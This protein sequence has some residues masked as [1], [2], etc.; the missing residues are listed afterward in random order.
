MQTE[1]RRVDMNRLDLAIKKLIPLSWAEP[2]RLMRIWIWTLGRYSSRVCETK[3]AHA[4]YGDPST[5]PVAVSL[6]SPLRIAHANW[7]PC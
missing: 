4:V 1:P 6:C 2:T 3:N 7:I 5:I